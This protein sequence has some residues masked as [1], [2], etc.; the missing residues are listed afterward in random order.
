[1]GELL[2]KKKHLATFHQSL[3][4]CIKLYYMQ[5]KNWLH[6][7][8]NLGLNK[9][10]KQINDAAKI[11]ITVVEKCFKEA[12]LSAFFHKYESL[13]LSKNSKQCFT[14]LGINF[15]ANKVDSIKFYAHVLE[16]MTE[17][18]I[19]QFLPKTKDYLHYLPL[20]SKGQIF[21]SENVG[22]VLEIKFKVDEK[23]PSYGFFYLLQNTSE[24]YQAVGLPKNIPL[25]MMKDCIGV[26]VNFEYKEKHELSKRYY[27]FNQPSD[28]LFFE[29]N[30]KLPPLHHANHIE[31]AEGI[32]LSKVN[33][34]AG[35]LPNLHDQTNL[36]VESERELIQF[37][38]EKYGLTNI[39]YG[40]YSNHS[41]KSVYFRDASSPMNTTNKK[42]NTIQKVLSK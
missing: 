24:S 4:N 41:I 2:N 33:A 14:T 5:I 35:D 30:F 25:E 9:A 15:K 6:N 39:G 18:E 38:N 21:N 3:L 27:Y 29:Q 8:S 36:F 22:T 23:N 11:E 40:I 1:M 37:L 17:T 26:G 19:L 31:Y 42:I 16:E 28:K 13:L 20:K 10:A 7:I 12:H 32:N 34:Y